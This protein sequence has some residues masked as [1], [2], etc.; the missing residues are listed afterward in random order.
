MIVK[1]KENVALRLVLAPQRIVLIDHIPK[2]GVQL[3]NY[4]L[5]LI[6]PIRS[7]TRDS[8]H[9]D[10]RVETVRLLR[11]LI[12]NIFQE[13]LITD[14]ITIIFRIR[15]VRLFSIISIRHIIEISVSTINIP[16]HDAIPS[17]RISIYFILLNQNTRHNSQDVL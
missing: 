7:D 9:N 6:V 11:L 5:Q 1:L 16:V 10:H 15:K 4:V 2:L 17:F 14:I 3:T 8:I 13:L 12:P